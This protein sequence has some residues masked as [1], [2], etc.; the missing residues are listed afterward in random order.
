MP[1]ARP[2]LTQLIQRAS[3]DIT[4]GLQAGTALLR[5]S[6]LTILG[7]VIAK[8]ANALYGYLDF[9]ALQANPFTATGEYA[10]AWGALK[11][12]FTKGATSA[13]GPITFVGTN[14]IVVPAGTTV[15]RGDGATFVT[16]ADATIAMQSASAPV[17]AAIA[18]SAGNTP[19]GT[20]FSL[21]KGIAGI[22][23]S[24]VAAAGLQ[25]GADVEAI[26]DFKA[27]YL[28]IYAAPPQGGAPGDY[29]EWAETMSGVTRAWARPN[30]MGAG[31]VVVYFMMDDAE[32]VYGGFPQGT[33]GVAT[34]ETRDTPATGDQLLVANAIYPLRPATA[35]VYAVAPGQNVLG[36]TIAGMAGAS[37]ATKGLV[38]AA[39][40]SAILTNSSPGGVTLSDGTAGGITQIS[41]IEKAIAAIPAAAGFVI[42]GVAASAGTVNPGMAGNIQSNSGFLPVFGSVVFD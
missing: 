11:G 37:V 27:R 1:F 33:N 34:A 14:G 30:G 5:F 16:T 10:V 25:G 20:S 23:S 26:D 29:L 7:K 13:G 21:G 36:F 35:L 39:I 38:Q 32:A 3:S 41:A 18:G 31:T 22:S 17:V 9:I 40:Q 24:A 8:A 6:N 4:A 42:T 15:I 2:T 28:Q 19:A 12:V